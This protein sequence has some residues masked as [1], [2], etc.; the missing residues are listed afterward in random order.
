MSKGKKRLVAQEFPTWRSRLAR[1][2]EICHSNLRLQDAGFAG[3]R[4]ILELIEGGKK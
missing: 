2:E 4:E 1:I 3:Y